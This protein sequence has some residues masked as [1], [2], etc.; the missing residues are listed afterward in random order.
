MLPTAEIVKQNIERSGMKLVSSELFGSS[1]ART[2]IEWRDRFHNAWPNIEPLGFD[3]RF[4][5]MWEYYLAYCQAGFETGALN[6]G[7]YKIARAS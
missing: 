1:Y 2:L 6:V 3:I 5:R 4:K 7:L